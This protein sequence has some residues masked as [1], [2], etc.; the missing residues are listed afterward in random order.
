MENIDVLFECISNLHK[1][2]LPLYLYFF[3]TQQNACSK[4]LADNDFGETNSAY[5]SYIYEESVSTTF[6]YNH[7]SHLCPDI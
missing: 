1:E 6:S 7:L 4:N 3:N 2:H 5:D